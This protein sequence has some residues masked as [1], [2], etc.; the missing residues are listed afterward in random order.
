MKNFYN[1]IKQMN[2][3]TYEQRE[4][5]LRE[6]RQEIKRRKKQLLLAVP[7]NIYTIEFIQN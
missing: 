6:M 3:M 7:K 4:A 2:K 5:L 1:Q